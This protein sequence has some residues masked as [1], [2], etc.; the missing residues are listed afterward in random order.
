MG[1]TVDHSL[2]Q[3]LAAAAKGHTKQATAQLLG[4]TRQTMLNYCHRWKSVADAF[5]QERREL[6]DLAQNGLRFAIIDRQPWALAFT[7]K[8]LGK[9][10][11]FTERTEIVGPDG[12][13]IKIAYVNDWRAT[14]TD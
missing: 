6:V 14:E 2:E 9:D 10:E 12:G 5:E 3:V 13:P 11:G 4:C 7:L 8:T 1:R